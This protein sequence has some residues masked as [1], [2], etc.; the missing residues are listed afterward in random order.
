M[1]NDELKRMEELEKAAKEL[2][3]LKAANAVNAQTEGSDNDGGNKAD[4]GKKPKFTDKAKAAFDKFW[5]FSITP[6]K[7]AT[8]VLI[9]GAAFLGFK[10]AY[11][12]GRSDAMAEAE[13]NGQAVLP[14]NGGEQLA[15]G[16]AAEPEI[17]ETQFSDDATEEVYESE[18]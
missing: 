12:K 3:E 11:G 14:D 10:Y 2:E 6:K 17:F 16:T 5:N 13:F 7:I 18:E 4:D 8:G 1:T 15:L 9:G